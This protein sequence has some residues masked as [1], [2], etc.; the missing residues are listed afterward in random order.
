MILKLTEIDNK[1]FELVYSFLY[2]KFTTEPEHYFTPHS[3][4]FL[5][6]VNIHHLIL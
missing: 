2:L 4:W 5:C 3:Q 6:G 1:S